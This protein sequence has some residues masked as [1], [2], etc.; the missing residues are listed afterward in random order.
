MQKLAHYYPVILAGGSGTRLWPISRSSRP[1]PLSMRMDGHTL[2]EQA[3]RHVRQCFTRDAIF[4]STNA[5][6]AREVRSL[7]KELPSK[8]FI[9]EPVMRNTGPAVGY[10]ALKI[11]ERDPDGILVTVN[12]DA[13]IGDGAALARALEFAYR[14][15]CAYPNHLVFL[16]INPSYPET[17]YGYLEMGIPV[18]KYGTLEAFTLLSFKEKPSLRVAKKYLTSWRYL[19]N[20]TMVTARADHFLSLFDAHLPAVA[21]QLKIIARARTANSPAVKKAFGAMPSISIDFGIFEKQKKNMLV[22]PA[23]FGWADIGSFRTIHEILS[24]KTRQNVAKGPLLAL[25]AENNLV[26]PE[27]EKL[28]SLIG[29]N[30]VV[31]VETED[32]ILLCH[33][34]RTQDV[35]K[36]VEMLK[37]RKMMKYL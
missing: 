12:S 31:M 11:H 28:V 23:E 30:N 19:W 16:G 7:L 25:D 6:S 35:R 26:L 15:V 36:V 17:S 9:I 18:M 37:K 1:K 27:R 21:R 32:A 13:W 29:V 34:E 10:A 3:Y 33:K 24:H 2:L 4:V 20:P 14:A 5:C 8:N 22:I